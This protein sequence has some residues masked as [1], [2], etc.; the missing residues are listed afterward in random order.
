VDDP[1]QQEEP[2]HGGKNELN[3]GHQEPTLDQLAKSRDEKAAESRDHVSG[4]SLTSHVPS[5]VER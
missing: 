2:E 5:Q 4:R 3:D 1:T